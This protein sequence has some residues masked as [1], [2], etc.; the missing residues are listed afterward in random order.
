MANK[1]FEAYH[2]FLLLLNELKER[3]PVLPECLRPQVPQEPRQSS[4]SRSSR[5]SSSGGS[6]ANEKS[7]ANKKNRRSPSMDNESLNTLDIFN[8]IYAVLHSSAYR[9]SYRKFFKIDSP[10]IPYPIDEKAFSKLISLGGE[11]RHLHLLDNK[12]FE[13]TDS[14]S[15]LADNTNN[16]KV[17]KVHFS[18]EKVFINKDFYFDKVPQASWDFIIGTNQPA[19]KWLHD[20]IGH[21]LNAEDIRHYRIMV[22]ALTETARVMEQEG[23]D[24]QA[25][26]SPTDS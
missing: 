13:K 14:E 25:A 12:K 11:L 7:E 24:E 2:S 23:K 26:T 16:T 9:E 4:R 3:P 1:E 8:Y 20:R 22:L 18:D 21:T 5:K 10:R 17:E 15:A 19:Q 6:E